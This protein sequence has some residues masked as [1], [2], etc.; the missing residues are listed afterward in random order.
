MSFSLL[1]FLIDLMNNKFKT[2]WLKNFQE[3]KMLKDVSFYLI[4][5]HVEVKLWRYDKL[6]LTV[7]H[8]LL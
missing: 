2:L 5:Q 6:D 1:L 8:L 3:I 7:N 4:N